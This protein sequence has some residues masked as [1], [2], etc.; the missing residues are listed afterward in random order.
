M[1]TLSTPLNTAQ[2]V[3]AFI[4]NVVLNFPGFQ[5]HVEIA[6]GDLLLDDSRLAYIGKME[7]GACAWWTS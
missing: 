3:D 1:A 7:N 2:A 6:N 4:R 5:E